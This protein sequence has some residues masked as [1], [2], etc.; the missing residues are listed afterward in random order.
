MVKNYDNVCRIFDSRLNL[1]LCSDAFVKAKALQKIAAA[2]ANAT[3][4]DFDLM[5]TGYTESGLVPQQDITVYRPTMKNWHAVLSDI[6]VRTSGKPSTILVDSLNGFFG[7][8][9]DPDSGMYANACMMM[10]SSIAYHAGGKVFL[11]GVANLKND[12][13][14][15]LPSGRQVLEGVAFSKF[16]LSE[17]NGITVDALSAENRIEGTHVL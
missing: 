14:L 10:M 9:D 12:T 7:I 17:Q 3:L 5:Y 16:F 11:T 2:F 6:A 15:L 8:F 4:L 13:W 1:L